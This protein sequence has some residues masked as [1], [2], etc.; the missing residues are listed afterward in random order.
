MPALRQASAQDFARLA[1]LSIGSPSGTTA[2][3]RLLWALWLALI[4]IALADALFLAAY[5]HGVFDTYLWFDE[6]GPVEDLQAV[7]LVVATLV[8]LWWSF[9]Q[10]R[11]G[12]II[13]LGLAAMFLA[14]FVRELDLRETGA[15]DW[16][17]WPFYGT[18][19]NVVIVAIFGLYALLPLRH[20]RALPDIVRA[21]LHPRTLLYLFAGIV[22]LSSG[23]AEASEKRF[24]Y[25][26]EVLEEWLE[27]N[28]YVIFLLAVTLFPYPD[29]ARQPRA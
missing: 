10:K 1:T 29:R 22:L 25:Q 6:D 2:T 26:A 18:G 24:G 12:R 23:L 27:L 11:E 13:D 16:L 7:V 21:F 19:Q 8:A 4:A 5:L 15:P 3:A 17:V 28:G 9:S 20:W 14:S